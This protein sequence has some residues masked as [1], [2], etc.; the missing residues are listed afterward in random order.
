[1]S[2]EKHIADVYGIGYQD[3]L[4][5]AY[6]SDTNLEYYLDSLL[7]TLKRQKYYDCRVKRLYDYALSEASRRLSLAG[8]RYRY[9]IERT[10]KLM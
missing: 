7:D 4:N 6:M 3:I 5:I 2:L 10:R 8:A 1:M 9:N